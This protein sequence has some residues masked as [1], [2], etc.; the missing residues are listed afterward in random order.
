M[1]QH[2]FCPHCEGHLKIG[3]NI[4]FIAKNERK[5]KGIILL[6]SEIGN[7]SSLKH[8][9]FVFRKGEVLQFFCPLCKA[10]LTSDIDDNLILI[11]MQDESGT[12]YKVYFSRIAGEYSTYKVHDD[13]VEATGDH[14]DRYTYFKLPDKLKNYLKR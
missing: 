1:E 3:E 14:A 7:Y 13:K 6:H 4:V 9:S 2:Y 10:S 5:E 8:P 12:N 11:N